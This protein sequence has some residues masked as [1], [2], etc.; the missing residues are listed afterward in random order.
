MKKILFGLIA[1]LCLL[2]MSASAA[3]KVKVYIFTKDGCTYCEKE[4]EYLKG[5]EGYN[6]TFE[7]IEYEMY[8][9]SW[10]TSTYY[11]L[12]KTVAEGLQKILIVRDSIILQQILGLAASS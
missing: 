10:N 7:V 12:G 2:P 5:L 11:N 8:D 6:K 4:M 9:A 1:L 3:D